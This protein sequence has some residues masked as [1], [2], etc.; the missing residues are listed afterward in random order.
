MIEPK[1]VIITGANSGLGFECAKTILNANKG[2]HVIMACRNAT[3]AETAKEK[4]IDVTGNK[5]ISVL[6]LDLAS[7]QSIRNF[8]S[9]F[10]A[11]NFP[12]LHGLINNAGT[13]I[14]NGVEYT[15]DGFEATFGTNHLGHFLLTNLLLEIFSEPARIIVV[16]SGT[17]DP[18]IQGGNRYTPMYLGA[19]ELANPTDENIMTGMQRYSTSKLANLLFS[20]E[21]ARKLN[22][23][24]ITVNAYD[25]SLVPETNLFRS[26]KNPIK[27]Y[28]LK[29]F[30]HA[31]KLF[32]VDVSTA[33]K[34]GSAMARLLLD[35][36]MEGV[37][38][39]YYHIFKEIQSSKQSYDTSLA[40]ELWD[41]SIKL[42]GLK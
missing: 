27:R 41:D 10:Q 42:T 40:S 22:G 13:Q 1:S 5:E 3:T 34:S 17:H 30:F 12:P 2:W 18:Y 20:Y 38:G 32:G 39:K 21:L 25:P 33:Q 8:V 37:T 9:N 19:N 6:E 16:S 31:L 4:L 7:L 11:S 26:I 28:Y 24:N 15:K 14:Q 23:K 35:E 29:T 36:T